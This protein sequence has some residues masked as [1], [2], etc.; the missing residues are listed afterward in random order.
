L[1]GKPMRISGLGKSS[2]KVDKHESKPI[3]GYNADADSTLT[4][5]KGEKRKAT[6]DG[7]SFDV[8]WLLSQLVIHFW[9]FCGLI[10]RGK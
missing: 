9:F 8:T 2:G 5:A 7:L 6:D 3:V 1:E 4:P 10:A